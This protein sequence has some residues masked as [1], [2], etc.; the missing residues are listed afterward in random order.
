MLPRGR[1]TRRPASAFFPWRAHLF[2]RSQGGLWAC[3]DLACPHRDPE[4]MAEGAD[5]GFGAVWLTQRDHC[6]CGA[7]VFEILACTECGAAHLVAGRQSGTMARLIPHRSSQADE[8]IIDEEPDLEEEI[9]P[10]ERDTVW[11]RPANGTAL[12]RHLNLENGQLYDNGAP[13]NARAIPIGVIENAETRICCANAAQARLQPQ[14]CGAPFFMGNV[15]PDMLERLA[16]PLPKPGL[17]MGGQRAITFSDSRQG[18]ARLA[19]KPSGR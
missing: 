18:V 4:L 6:A 17:P 9:S 14:R 13:E 16:Q 10:F 1:K 5:W 8:F 7:P 11:L 2:Q 3:V 19:A 12:D 15:L